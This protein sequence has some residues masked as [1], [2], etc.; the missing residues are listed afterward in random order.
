VSSFRTVE[1]SDR[2]Y[3]NAGLRFLTVKSEHLKGRGDI[4]V[5]VPEIEIDIKN[6]PIYILLHGVYGSAWAWAM[7][8]GAHITA[9]NL[10]S[11]G[12]I[13]PAI[14]AMPS[15][16]LW[17]DGSGYLTHQERNFAQ[18]IVSDVPTAI[19]EN[20]SGA[21]THSPWCIG[22]FSM[23]GY[24]ALVLG[25]RFPNKFKAISAHSSITKFEQMASF[26]EE[27]LGSFKIQGLEKDV[28]DFVRRK[29][30][31]LPPLRFD[32]GI[33]D[34]LLQANRELHRQLQELKIEHQYHEFKGGHEWPYWQKNLEHTLRFFDKQVTSWL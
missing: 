20:I 4:C 27:P 12:E 13:K 21:N 34:D 29:P 1:L 18:W 11:N 28:I 19:I 32:C 3:E 23:G 30:H 2:N 26:V 9:H 24:G 31:E 10:I 17:G 16:G 6:I 15:D 22:G 25:S 14:V 33:Q 7:K 5:Y 8:G